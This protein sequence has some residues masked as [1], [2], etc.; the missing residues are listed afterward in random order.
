MMD[1]MLSIFGLEPG[2]RARVF[3][4][5]SLFAATTASAIVVASA[6]K[7]LFLSTWPL[8]VLPWVFLLTGLFTAGLSLA[9][10]AA[11]KRWGVQSRY[12]TL[13]VL[14]VASFV[15]IGLTFNLAPEAMSWAVI[16]WCP[17]IGYLIAVQAWNIV[18]TMLPTRQSKRLIPVLAGIGTLGGCVGGAVVPLLLTV[19]S[20]EDLLLLAALL[21]IWPMA[22]VPWLL[23]RLDVAVVEPEARPSVKPAPV[24]V[25]PSGLLSEVVDGLKSIVAMPILW[26][27]ALFVFLMQAV[28]VLVDYQFSGELQARLG[29]DE[30]ASFLGMYYWIANGMIFVLALFGTNRLVQWMGI[31]LTITATSLLMVVG[32]G[33]YFVAGLVGFDGAFVIL[34]G[35]AFTERVGQYALTR[36]G[37]QMLVSPLESRKT[38]RAKTLIDGVIYRLATVLAAVPLLIFTPAVADLHLISPAIVLGCAVAAAV[39][40]LIAPHYRTALYK[41]LRSS[42]GESGMGRYFRRSLGPRAIDDLRH[43]L[44]SDD[45]ETRLYAIELIRDLDL[46]L[47]VRGVLPLLTDPDGDVAAAALD[48]AL[49]RKMELG[50]VVWRQILAPERP[51]QALREALAYLSQHPNHSLTEVVEPLVVH[52]DPRVAALA[53]LVSVQG[54]PGP[55]LFGQSQDL[56]TF[57]NRTQP[58]LDLASLRY[59]AELVAML[60]SPSPDKRREAVE[61]MGQLRLDDHV[62]PLFDC[63]ERPDLRPTAIEA[64][65]QYD[66]GLLQQIAAQLGRPDLPS[67]SRAGLIKVL[68]QR[69][70][71]EA[72][73]LLLEQAED[74]HSS[75]ANTAVLALWRVT[76][77]HELP[78]DAVWLRRR[79]LVEIERLKRYAWLDKVVE[80]LDRAHDFLIEEV[81]ILRE[82]SEDRTFRLLALLY[83]RNAIHRAYLN[84]KSPNARQRSNAIELLDQHVVDPALKVIVALIER[85]VGTARRS[86]DLL[87]AI[88]YPEIEDRLAEDDPWLVHIWSWM[89]RRDR[90]SASVDMNDPVGRVFWLKKFPIFAGIGGSELRSVVGAVEPRTYGPGQYIC[91]EGE[92]G[93][94]MYMILVGRVEV[95]MGQDTLAT[96]G[97][98]EYFGELALLDDAPRSA[99]VRAAEATTLLALPRDLFMNMLEL[100]PSFATRIIR[101]LSQRLRATATQ[102]A[103]PA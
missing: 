78:I 9:Y 31:G 4:L 8:S 40:L 100:H 90:D 58:K 48:V 87:P 47:D 69:R 10:V 97:D 62:H 73:R 102:S 95:V 5:G 38:E 22:S 54:E 28:S 7:A 101:I 24:E 11:M 56:E 60:D 85:R 86:A 44:R 41:A 3:D 79:V 6:S 1:R 25:E 63:L 94:E 12:I 39:G 45:A 74:D 70:E 93:L 66:G 72:L 61:A 82:A 33:G 96:L 57:V 53:G 23:R 80:P 17:A 29:R 77:A 42:E 46:E 27:L 98:G 2:D 99:S 30:L 20:S 68:E 21:L 88:L 89:H 83:D 13:L 84:Y 92:E 59:V 49:Q 35:M 43:R 50:A 64:L 19:L 75:V 34:L 55:H 14:A 65:V 36:S 37:V 81:S 15:V 103:R 18:A 16:I 91:R 51:P 76:D 52:E 71:P 32:G 26:R 67:P